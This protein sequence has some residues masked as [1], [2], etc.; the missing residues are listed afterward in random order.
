MH[1]NPQGDELTQ[2]L[3]GSSLVAQQV[4]D[5]PLPLQWLGH[6]G[7]TVPSLAENVHMLRVQPKRKRKVYVI[8]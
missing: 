8:H 7:G 2:G 1:K 6:C 3:R 5:L 4:K